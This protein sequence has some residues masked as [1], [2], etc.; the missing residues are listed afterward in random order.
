MPAS[1]RNPI[2]PTTRNAAPCRRAVTTF[3][4]KDAGTGSDNSGWDTGRPYT[5]GPS[6]PA[7]SSLNRVSGS[8][9]RCVP[10]RCPTAAYIED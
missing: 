10:S 7:L 8:P 9:P 1:T 3:D 6:A 4:I 2:A 5:D